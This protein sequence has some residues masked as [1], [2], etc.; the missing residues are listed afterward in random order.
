MFGTVKNGIHGLWIMDSDLGR[1]DPRPQ[2]TAVGS[3]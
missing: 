2:V 1:V 3:V